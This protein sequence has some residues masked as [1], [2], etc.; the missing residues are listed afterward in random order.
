MYFIKLFPPAPVS[1]IDGEFTP[2]T[3]PACIASQMKVLEEAHLAGKVL[4]PG[5]VL[6][7]PNSSIS[8]E[9]GGIT[10]SQVARHRMHR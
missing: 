8:G 4:P 2:P 7:S 9:G 3:S 1:V 6:G 10:D 5:G